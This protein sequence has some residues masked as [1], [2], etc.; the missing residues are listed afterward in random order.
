MSGAGVLLVNLGSPDA[1]TPDAVSRYL[2]EFL[3][4]RRV[5]DTPWPI[6][7][8]MVH[9]A[10]VPRRR[11]ASAAAYQKIW[12]AEGSPLLVI[13]RAVQAGLQARVSAPV[14]LAM[15]YGQPSIAGAVQRLA[16]AGLDRLLVIPLFPHYAMSSYESA[17]Q[18]V[19]AVAHQLAPRLALTIQPP[20]GED[21]DYIA[22]LVASAEPWLRREHDHLLFSFHG[23]PER[24]LRKS[25]PTQSHCLTVPNCCAVPSPAHATCYRAQCF[26]TVQ[27]FA[28]QAGLAAGRYS[29]AFQSRFGREPWLQP[30]T[31][32][33]I[34]RL[35]AAG[36]QNLL[37]I[38]PGSLLTVW[39]RWRRSACAAGKLSSR[40]AGAS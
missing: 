26:K 23:L 9:L 3:L 38:C 37:V 2:R 39:K 31:D 30:Y 16:A 35:A 19:K 4:D 18:C 6:R 40:P 32:R 17:V 1:P 7:W 11:K 15:R 28:R 8:A 29:V 14:E 27:A 10:I 34:A 25:D 36:V 5:L 24:H 21:P 12:T 20:F 33:E 22:A 13:S